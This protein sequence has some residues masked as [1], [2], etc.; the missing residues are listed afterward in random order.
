[1]AREATNWAQ[2]ALLCL[3]LERLLDDSEDEGLNWYLR[4]SDT[5]IGQVLNGLS[6]LREYAEDRLAKGGGDGA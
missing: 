6:H 3:E 4:D 2:I 5:Y 1:M